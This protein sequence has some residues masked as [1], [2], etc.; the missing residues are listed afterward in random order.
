[1]ISSTRLRRFCLTPR[2]DR[3][4]HAL[5]FLLFGFVTASALAQ[6]PSNVYRPPNDNFRGQ[7]IPTQRFIPQPAPPVTF[8]QGQTF[9]TVPQYQSV[10]P[11]VSRGQVIQQVP[12]QYL[13]G[14]QNP[15]PVYQPPGPIVQGQVIQGQV[16]QGPR[17]I[18]PNQVSA[19][20]VENA[21]LKRSL[22]KARDLLE[23]FQVKMDGVSQRNRE[24]EASIAN[25]KSSDNMSDDVS[26]E[27][28]AAKASAIEAQNRMSGLND[29]LQTALGNLETSNGALDRQKQIGVELEE[30]VRELQKATQM[31][32]G[33][34]AQVADMEKVAKQFKNQN[35]ML[36]EK[37]SIL[38]TSLR[39]R[40]TQLEK[41]RTRESAEFADVKSRFTASQE[42][43]EQLQTKLQAA[44]AKAAEMATPKTDPASRNRK[45]SPI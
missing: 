6:T 40:D 31:A 1:M 5:V 32:A 30:K 14:R 18:Q 7:G 35:E 33:N 20:Q 28:A 27:L 22:V 21:E 26:K 38:Q 23:K 34:E 2:A 42:M 3:G 44:L 16:I 25:L 39:D 17:T 13:P 4:L 43:N 36:T 19:A 8:Q 37:I 11:I 10:P 45:N 12:Q 41:M 15:T 24:L 29:Q 9:R